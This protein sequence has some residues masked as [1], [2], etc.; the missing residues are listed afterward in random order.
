MNSQNSFPLNIPKYCRLNAGRW[1]LILTLL[2]QETLWLPFIFWMASET[3]E[4]QGWPRTC[5]MFPE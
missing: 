4:D 3:A 1:K 2:I 5:E